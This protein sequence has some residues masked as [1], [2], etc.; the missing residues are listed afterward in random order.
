MGGGEGEAG[1]G[2]G[3]AGGGRRG[4]KPQAIGKVSPAKGRSLQSPGSA[5]LARGAVPEDALMPMH[6]W[7]LDSD[8][9]KEESTRFDL[10]EA[11]E[12]EA[13]D[14][15]WW[16]ERAAPTRPNALA[17]IGRAILRLRLYLGWSQAE[18]EHR[19]K[20]DQTTISRLE[21]GRQGGLNIRR[22]AAILDALQVGEVIF[23]Q[24]PLI[25]PPTNLELMLFGDRWERAKREADR[26]LGWPPGAPTA[27]RRCPGYDI[28]A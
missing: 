14:D 12:P 18:L 28:D 25:T 4:A 26:R 6:G 2:E 11:D 23:D 17:K 8:E 10:A 21:R 9:G 20:V 7:A 19:S 15:L 3:E 5:T 27:P 13:A 16:A 24:P 22:L 1:G